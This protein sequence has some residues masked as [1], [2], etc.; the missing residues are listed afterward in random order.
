MPFSSE[1]L[2]LLMLAAGYSPM[3]CLWA[4]SAGNIAGGISTF[5]IGRMGN[6]LWLDRWGV[7][8][9]ILL[10]YRPRIDRWGAPLAFL[11]FVPGLGD[12][13]LLAL[14][15]FRVSPAYA[16]IYM[17]L[18]K[19]LRYVALVYTMDYFGGISLYLF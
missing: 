2:L 1:A 18:G 8:P 19:L 4:A 16:L 3:G 6:P 13:L 9:D 15:F 11:S 17:A 10:K 12:V 5:G 14:G 7:S